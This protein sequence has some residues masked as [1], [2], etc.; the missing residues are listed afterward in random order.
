MDVTAI[1]PSVAGAGGEM[2][3]SGTDL[4]RFLDAL[5]RG[6]VLRPAELREMMK[7]RPTGNP[8]G[9][10]GVRPRPGEQATALRRPLLGA[11]R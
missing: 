11:H 6:R 4:N 10:P 8:D 9:R 5:V 2:I 3:S 7:T 1:N